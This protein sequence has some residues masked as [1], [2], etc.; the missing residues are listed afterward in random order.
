LALVAAIIAFV[1]LG[2]A[3]QESKNNDDAD[4]RVFAGKYL[5]A[6]F[7][8]LT[9]SKTPESM[10]EL[11]APR[12]RE[13][14]SGQRLK[15]LMQESQSATPDHKPLKIDGIA[16]GED[17]KVDPSENGYSVQ[18]PRDQDIQ[19][20]VDGKWLSAAELFTA[21]FGFDGQESD[22]LG[23]LELEYVDGK[24]RAANCFT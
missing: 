21:V 10:L 9:G 12:C 7:N 6:G 1:L 5:M 2:S 22:G 18:L 19:L 3:T 11:Y 16:F 13:G 23:R 20:L 4:P 8:L 14:D 24:L 17:L 15:A